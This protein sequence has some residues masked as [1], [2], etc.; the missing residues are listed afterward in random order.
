MVY[1]Y[2][3]ALAIY[4]FIR[5]VYHKHIHHSG[6]LPLR[7]VEVDAENDAIEGILNQYRQKV[8]LYHRIAKDLLV[9]F[10]RPYCYGF[11][12]NIVSY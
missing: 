10:S 5:D 2:D 4:R 11:W 3:A 6:D 8:I 12:I 7:P 9:T 1:A